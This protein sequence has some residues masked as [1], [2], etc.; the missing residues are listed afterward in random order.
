MCLILCAD[1]DLAA[2]P[3]GRIEGGIRMAVK[4]EALQQE[5]REA[6]ATFLEAVRGITPAQAAFKPDP[7]R[8]CIRDIAEHITL[9]EE[10]MRKL[11]RGSIERTRAG[12]PL[13]QGVHPDK[14]LTIQEVMAQRFPKKGVAPEVVQPKTND[15]LPMLIER[16]E[17]LGRT[18][19]DDFKLF[20][21]VD[22][23]TLLFPHPF[24]A[25]LD[26]SQWLQLM[27]VH[28]RQHARQALEVKAAPGYP[29]G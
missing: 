25:L 27:P 10:S 23:E 28:A 8:W 15:P 19:D 16:Y 14:G 21:E 12:R 20:A 29:P 4:L 18:L 6:R 1:D 7:D 9:A 5:I 2:N 13:Y 17:R 22:L 11:V 24:G 3:D 26:M